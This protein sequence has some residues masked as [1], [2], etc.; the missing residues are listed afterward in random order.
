MYSYA[1]IEDLKGKLLSN[2][3]VDGRNSIKFIVD[4]GTEYLMFHNQDCCEVVSID[5]IC[6]DIQDLIGS[7][8]L[9][10]EEVSHDDSPDAVWRL[11]KEGITDK[12][13]EAESETWTFYKIDTSK[14]GVT[15]R[16]YGSSN[17]YY[18]ERVD[19]MKSC[20]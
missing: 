2:V 20:D 13:Y 17:G 14:G 11:L 15:I 4:D 1:S 10:A 7:E 16:W 18:S 6:G 8:I 3:E 19:F 5:D 9:I 12:E